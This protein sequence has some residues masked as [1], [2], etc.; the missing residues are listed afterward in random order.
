MGDVDAVGGKNASLGEMIVHLTSLGVAVP[1]GFAVTTSAYRHFVESESLGPK[2]HRLMQGLDVEDVSELARVGRETRELLQSAPM[3]ADLREAISSALADLSSNSAQSTSAVSFAV[4]SSATAEDTPDA[5]FAGQQESFLNV[6]GEEKILEAIK[7]VFASLF[8]DR[9]IAYRAHHGFAEREVA[10]SV[11]VQRMVR[12]DLA[13]SGVMFSLDT[14]SG[15]EDVVFITGSYGLG[16]AVVQGAVNPDEFYV[17]KPN[18][19]ASRPAVLSKSLGSKTVRM[20]Y[21]E[22]PRVHETIAARQDLLLQTWVA[23]VR[24]LDLEPPSTRRAGMDFIQ[25]SVTD[26][27]LMPRNSTGAPTCKPRTESSK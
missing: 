12:S 16:E 24:I 11:A 8:N 4:R 9:A 17:Y 27:T 25:G 15:F 26:P 22:A 2:I 3:P 10:I 6:R 19:R 18:L 23:G 5:S 7:R 21:G 20:V 14:E 1:G 13:S